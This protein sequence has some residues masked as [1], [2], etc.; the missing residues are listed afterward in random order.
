MARDGSVHRSDL[1]RF[2]AILDQAGYRGPLSL[3]YNFAESDEREGLRK[4]LAY[5]RG[6]LPAPR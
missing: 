2:I 3:E 5:L 6:F 1:K 4:G